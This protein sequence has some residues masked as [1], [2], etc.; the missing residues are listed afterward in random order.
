[1]ANRCAVLDPTWSHLPV[2]APTHTAHAAASHYYASP[3]WLGPAAAFE[4]EALTSA[5]RA[6]MS[7]AHAATAAASFYSPTT[8]SSSTF[9]AYELLSDGHDAPAPA[10]QSLAGPKGGRVSKRKPRPS[11]R[12]HT[13]YIT[14]DPAN[15]RRMVQEITGFPVPGTSSGVQAAAASEHASDAPSWPPAPAC[16]LPTLDTS[17]FLLDPAMTVPAPE[18]KSSGG[19]GASAVA[20]ALGADEQ[21]SVLQEL[22]AMACAPA[23][24]PDFPTL[25]SWGI[26]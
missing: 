7:P 11:R 19:G 1:M 20:A 14:A 2:P 3:A 4:N 25:E 23:F 21:C 17:A 13:T 22:E 18:G 24:M 6:S 5:L 16:V 8:P 26:I 10:A 15:F 12:A 9:F